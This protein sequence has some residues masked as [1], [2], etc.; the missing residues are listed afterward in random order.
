MR[1]DDDS[2]I[3]KQFIRN[4]IQG[5]P[6]QI[7]IYGT[8]IHTKRLLCEPAGQESGADCITKRV[9]GL[10]DSGK[11]GEW[12][13]GKKVMSAKEAGAV[14]GAYIVILA[15]N[16]VIHTIFRRIEPFVKDRKI[17]VYDIN[18]NNLT[19]RI[20]PQ[21][22][23]YDS[24]EERV[25]RAVFLSE[26]YGIC[27]PKESGF[28]TF[29]PE[30]KLDIRDMSALA[31]LLIAPVI[32]KY[33]FWLVKKLLEERVPLVLFPSR[34]GFL[35]MQIYQ[36][37][38]MERP[39]LK[40]P[41]P[42]YL[43][44][45]RRASL[46][47]A[48]K[49]RKDIEFIAKLPSA[50]TWATNIRK[51]FEIDFLDFP[52]GFIPD[53][54]VKLALERSAQERRNYLVYLKKAG[55]LNRKAAMT[56]FVAVGTVQGALQQITGDTYKGYYFLRR[57]PDSSLTEQL[58]AVSLYGTYGDFEMDCNLYRFYYFLES[59]MTSDEPS[60]KYMDDRGNA[61]FYSENRSEKTI[62]ILRQMH[63]AILEY[64]TD[65]LK[66]LPDLFS[67][68][69]PVNLYDEILGYFSRDFSDI[70]QALLDELINV[71]EFLE[72]RVEDCNR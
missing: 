62:K 14:E 55:V 33:M 28:Q 7:I 27:P 47:A 21:I 61:C 58:D 59:V 1:Y 44:T 34:D 60:L 52:D 39:D 56:D 23:Q 37:I 42:V 63:A 16:A 26:G 54:V 68:N 13:Y 65:L 51:R 12:M 69:A 64:C 40:L 49:E 8:G 25:V 48:A 31:R 53:E 67:W 4:F 35:L 6:G 5:R 15:R 50:G 36:R 2:Y 66:Q 43:Y 3:K 71:D 20:R 18:G 38:Q 46:I 57:S 22:E 32:C 45:S 11:T 10:M 30:K 29:V 19:K 24:P 9:A 41:E 70:P 17:P 72:K